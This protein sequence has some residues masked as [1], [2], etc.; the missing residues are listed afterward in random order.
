[1]SQYS[2]DSF[3]AAICP[4]I[5]DAFANTDFLL[6][7]VLGN[8]LSQKLWDLSDRV[9]KKLKEPDPASTMQ[10]EVIDD[11][12]K[13][14]RAIQ[15]QLD[16]QF[17][18]LHPNAVATTY[19][20]LNLVDERERLGEQAV[21]NA[22][23]IIEENFLARVREG[24]IPAEAIEPLL[25]GIN[26][27]R[28]PAFFYANF[29]VVLANR[30]LTGRRSSAPMGLTSCL[31]EVAIFAA[32]AMTMPSA[33]I[34]NVIALT[35]A[36]H[37]TAFGWTPAGE[38]WWLY[39]KNKLFSRQDWAQLTREQFNGDGQ[40]AFDHFFKDMEHIVSVAG[41]FDLKT[42]KSGI[43]DEHRLAIIEKLDLFFGIRLS[44]LSA[45]LDQPITVLP[46]SPLAPVL[47]KLLGT[48][49]LERT[50][51][52][53]L[54][55]QAPELLQVLYSYRSLEVPDLHPYLQVARHQPLSKERSLT[56]SSR[57]E[58]IEIVRA[59]QATESIF[60]DRNRIAMPDETLRLQTGT[61]RDKALLLHVLLEHVN[62]AHATNET[63]VTLITALDS[64]V[65]GHD[66]CISLNTLHEATR[67]TE[68]ILWQLTD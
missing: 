41:T 45:G 51:Q 38:P 37:Y 65:C 4:N 34:A 55:A 23:A 12:L 67:P 31:D 27:D 22:L 49:S 40:A 20:E 57:Q 32:L 7:L 53:L 3:C 26:Q 19:G 52:H 48:Q 6:P 9:Q 25:E 68:G 11:P 63:F 54:T 10:A 42:G 58:A 43:I 14:I 44:Q 59:I 1:M 50:R 21:N 35:S 30:A 64:F 61:D 5:F 29:D 47:R 28:F 60:K 36:S 39:G 13:L 33:D 16:R 15:H 17:K 18:H 56:L 66:S 2:P 46:E 8:L 62:R 24:S